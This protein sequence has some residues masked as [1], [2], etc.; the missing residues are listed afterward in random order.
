MEGEEVSRGLAGKGAGL[1]R[2]PKERWKGKL[3][4]GR[5]DEGNRKRRWGEDNRLMVELKFEQVDG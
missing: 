1:G 3:G 5:L 2:R 4:G